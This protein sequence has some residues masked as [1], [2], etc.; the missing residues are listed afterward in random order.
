M[1]LLEILK[2]LN[3]ET[4]KIK[5]EDLYPETPD[6]L[7]EYENVFNTLLTL[8]PQNSNLQ[9]KIETV[10]EQEDSPFENSIIDRCNAINKDGYIIY[11]QVCGIEIS[12]NEL[13]SLSFVE[14]SEIINSEIFPKTIEE[15]SKEEIVCHCLYEMTFY[16]FTMEEIR[17]VKNIIVDRVSEVEEELK[18]A[19]SGSKFKTIEDIKQELL[20]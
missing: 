12:S 10:E 13:F 2:I 5:L 1:K 9:I 18:K 14:W 20:K 17:K 15:F 19:P 3:F 16:G 7:N 8:E 4:L 11:F 6:N